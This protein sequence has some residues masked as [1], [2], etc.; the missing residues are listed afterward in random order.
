MDGFRDDIFALED[1]FDGFAVKNGCSSTPTM[2]KDASLASGWRTAR[3]T[4]V[5]GP[6]CFWMP[7]FDWFS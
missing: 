3:R 2:Q 6:H 1:F 5:E 4:H 7:G